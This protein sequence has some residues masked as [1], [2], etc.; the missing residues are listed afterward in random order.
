MP[1]ARHTTFK[2]IIIV[3]EVSYFITFGHHHSFIL[4]YI[5]LQV[6]YYS[7][8]KVVTYYSQN[9]AGTLG[10][11]LSSGITVIFIIVQ[12]HDHSVYKCNLL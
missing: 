6:L 12:S 2:T 7:I 8:V 11:G 1:L 3:L 4:H 5:C 9:Y 10:S